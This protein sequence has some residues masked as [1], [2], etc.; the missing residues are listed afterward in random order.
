MDLV[1]VVMAV[2][3]GMPYLPEAVDSIRGQSLREWR[4]IVVDDASSDGSASYL[5]SLR[6]TRIQVMRMGVNSGQGAARNHALEQCETR[7]V[8]VI[9]ADDVSHRDRLAGQVEFFEANPRVGVVGT[10]FTYL[11]ADGRTGFGSPLPLTHREIYNNLLHGRHAISNGSVCFRTALLKECGGYGRSRCGEDWDIFLRLGERQLL[12]NLQ[13]TYHYY[14]VH[15]ASTSA[16]QLS[17]MRLQYSFAADAAVRR[18]A[19]LP[20]ISLDEYVSAL[21]NRPWRERLAS[22]LLVTALAEYR[23]A[24]YDILHGQP[25]SGYSR[26]ALAAMMSPSFAAHRLRRMVRPR[27]RRYSGSA[28]KPLASDC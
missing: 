11:G 26:M 6:D 19:R 18:A 25:V 27:G 13:E 8:A 5:D 12:A 3:N 2:Y 23:S 4:M 22:R 20:E 10:Q 9:D 21:A 24:V 14:R 15:R 1:T 16:T 17:E 7:Y 28:P